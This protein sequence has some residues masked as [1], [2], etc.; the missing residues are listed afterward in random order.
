MLI[1]SALWDTMNIAKTGRR[2]GV[3]SDARHRF[4]DDDLRFH[5]HLIEG[6][7]ALQEGVV[8]EDLSRL[9]RAI[10]DLRARYDELAAAARACDI[11]RFERWEEVLE[12]ADT[13]YLAPTDKEDKQIEREKLIGV[14][15]FEL[16]RQVEFGVVLGKLQ[17]R[18]A[19]DEEKKE[20][21]ANA[22]REKAKEEKK[23]LFENERNATRRFFFAP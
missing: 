14:A 20:A 4:E 18:L 12:L 8:I 21:A 19:A 11:G 9:P 22:A 13:H 16:G 3:V 7:C 5:V 17:A 1:E 15:N 23:D 6:S 10:D 2:L